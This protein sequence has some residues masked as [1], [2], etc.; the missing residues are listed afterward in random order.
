MQAK[1]DSPPKPRPKTLKRIAEIEAE[2]GDTFVNVVLGFAKSGEGKVATA[3]ILEMGKSTMIRAL[4]YFGFDLSVFPEPVETNGYK[5]QNRSRPHLKDNSRLMAANTTYHWVEI[6]GVR[7]TICGH[8]RRKGISHRT[9]F[10]RIYR[11]VPVERALM[12]AGMHKT[13]TNKKHIWRKHFE[14][15]KPKFCADRRS[16]TDQV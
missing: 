3:G 7:D 5:A 11:G 2:F 9:V 12:R 15:S 16:K 4:D 13:P 14:N 6:D 8:A 10:N 1:N